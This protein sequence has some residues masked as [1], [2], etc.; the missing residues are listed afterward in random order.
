MMHG[1]EKSDGCVVPEISPNNAG[2]A[3]PRR[4]GR[5]G[6]WAR[7]TPSGS[8]R[9]GHCAGSACQAPPH[10][11][12]AVLDGLPQPRTPRRYHPSQEP[13]AGIPH[14]GSARG[15][16]SNAHPYRDKDAGH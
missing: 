8:T 1:H 14:A 7:G 5:E 3:W 12:A 13:G 16:R 6:T 2:L 10:G 11:G 4:G 15:V 9:P